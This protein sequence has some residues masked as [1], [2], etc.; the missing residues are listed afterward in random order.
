MK[1]KEKENKNKKQVKILLVRINH[2]KNPKSLTKFPNSLAILA[3]RAPCIAFS[4]ST[5]YIHSFLET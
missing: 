2:L 4:K 3:L 1:K 5:F